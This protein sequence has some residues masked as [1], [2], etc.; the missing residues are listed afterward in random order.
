MGPFEITRLAAVLLGSGLLAGVIGVGG[1]AAA[2]APQPAPRPAEYL[3]SIT[4]ASGSLTGRGDKH[5]TLKLVGTRNHL[6]RFTDR[7]LRQAFVVANGDFAKRFKRYFNG[8]KPNAALSYTPAGSKIPVSIVVTIGQPR[9]SAE[10]ATWTFPATRIRER[11]DNLPDATRRIKPSRVPNPRSFTQASLVIDSAAFCDM[12][13]YP[14]WSGGYAVCEYGSFRGGDF[15]GW[16]L[17][18]AD[19]F[20]SDF[21]GAD[22]SGANLE[23]ADLSGANLS[24]ANFVGANLYRTSLEGANLYHANL[25]GVDVSDVFAG[26]NGIFCNSLGYDGSIDTE[27]C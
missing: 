11:P 10:H 13:N 23:N 4:S 7:P 1:A 12:R 22:F 5:L 26:D 6:T 8:D 2:P 14:V 20:A 24:G 16:N 25:T 3:F 27:N 15:H 18:N 19:L 9:W 21:S 17:V